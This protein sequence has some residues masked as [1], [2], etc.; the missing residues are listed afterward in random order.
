[1]ADR[2]DTHYHVPSLNNWFL[3]SSL[4]LLATVFWTVI[5]DWNAEWKT[6]QRDFRELELEHSQAALAEL[7]ARGD[8]VSEARL[9]GLVDEAT[10]QL[11]GK[12]T[13]LDEAA[14]EAYRLK[15]ERYAI[16]ERF[17]TAKSQFGWGKYLHEGDE[18][19]GA[20]GD[21]FE[22]LAEAKNLADALGLEFE[23]A[24]AA[25]Q[26]ADDHVAE[27]RSGL[28]ATEKDLALNTGDLSQVRKRI[29]AL[30][31]SDIVVQAADLVRD[32]PGLD[33][34]GPNLKVRKEIPANLT[35]ELNFTKKQRIDMCTTCHMAIDQAGFED[36]EQ[37]FATHPQLD[38]YLTSKSAHP[39]KEIGCTICHRGSGESLS[40]QH[41]DHRPSDEHEA[42]EWHE[43]HHWHKQHHWDYPM[44]SS[45][46]TEA[47]CIQCHTDT[48]ETIAD[49]AP[50]VTKGYRLFE[51]YGCYS[52]HKVE[53]FPTERRPGPSLKNLQAKLTP[54]FVDAWIT[55][56]K[57]FRPTTWMPQFYHLENWPDD[58]VVVV[59]EYGS[60]PEILGQQWNDTTVAAITAY[61]FDNHPKQELPPIPLQGDAERGRETFR[62]T[63]CLACHNMA[64]YPGEEPEYPD[65]AFEANESN[66]FG[67]NL[68]G[69]ASKIDKTWLYHWV[70]DPEAYWPGT[71]MPN[72]RLS[73]QEA[74]DIA[75]YLMVDPDGV[76]TDTPDGWQESSSPIDITALREQARWMFDKEGRRELDRRFAGENPDVRWDQADVLAV[77]VGEAS[78]RSAGCFSCHEI[79]GMEK[80][81][82]IGTELTKW[83]TKTVDKLDFGMAYR[84]ELAGDQGPLAP[85][86]HSYREGWLSRKLHHPRSYD[87]QKVKNPKERL[88]MPWFDF[89]DDQVDALRT[90]VVGLVNDE[91]SHARMEPTAEQ[92]SADIGARVV[93]Q[94]N[95]AACHEMD[96]G[97]ITYTP[98]GGHFSGTPITAEAEIRQLEGDTRNPTMDSMAALQEEFAGWEEYYEE[99]L[100]EIYIRLLAVSPEAGAPNDSVTIP[101]ENL[102]DVSPADGGA[103]VDLIT[104]Y[105]LNGVNVPDPEA[106]EDEDPYF[107]WT[108]G[109]D[110]DTDE[111]L[112]ADVDG[113]ER[114]YGGVDYD[115][116]RWTFAPPVLWNEG[117]KVQRD[118][119]F[120][121]LQDPVRLREQLR[122]RMPSF[123]F[124]RGEAESVADYFASKAR[125]AWPSRW[126][127]T[128]RLAL[129]RKVRPELADSGDHGW[130]DGQQMGWPVARLM[131][132]KGGGLPLDE[133][134]EGAGISVEALAGIERGYKPDVSAKFQ[135]VL[136]WGTGQG[137][138]MTGPP[139]ADYESIMRRSPSHLAAR[140]GMIPLGERVAIQGPNCYSCHPDPDGRIFPDTPIAWAPSLE[141]AR[142][143]LREEWVREW[144]WSPPSIYPGTSMPENFSADQPQYQ[145][146]FPSSD[147]RAQIQAV[148]DW[149]FNMDRA[150]P[151]SD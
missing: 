28:S 76:F 95:C 151:I 117:H 32:F 48:M 13:E 136:D 52:C 134:A 10:A 34:V 20:D 98:D 29:E 64:P 7:E 72:M 135:K 99:D 49:D 88:R 35:F 108:F 39:M 40:F 97:T 109:Y 127:R 122:V 130:T 65:L 96:P 141:Y 69:V 111:N 132:S 118:W 17:K 42:E 50:T 12:R 5:D 21:E 63:G 87:I 82:R 147:N 8:L 116:L 74:A 44:L 36:A 94:K 123:N 19:G 81:Q 146:V 47:S 31:P 61:L 103:F 62:V 70:K 131:T 100:E 113:V 54:G 115:K 138:S 104:D 143:R 77:A 46:D 86:D 68:R 1:M 73:E 106:A 137:F 139:T 133:V 58:E 41:V 110:E 91:V 128:M 75:E 18:L 59:S 150:A 3:F 30:D 114:A 43:E 33:F 80:G 57:A 121:F 102:I 124:A 51:Q 148:L 142:E 125:D 85:L 56:P 24:T 149:L 119:F 9:Q 53:W 37:P 93:R 26:T 22:D 145:S 78:V 71:R 25:Q 23:D 4:F 2:G 55:K 126:A 89:T 60:G 140:E 45:A 67:P 15:E 79:G 84:T 38:L 120:S 107:P 14:E 92:A 11:E 90:F 112:I 105:Y 27:L 83:G 66:S 101:L 16:E 129:G 6:Y 144:M